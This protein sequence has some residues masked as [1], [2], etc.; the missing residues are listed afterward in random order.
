VDEDRGGG[1]GDGITAV[2]RD[3]PAFFKGVFVE[4]RP[5]DTAAAVLLFQQSDAID[6][7]CFPQQ[8]MFAAVLPV[9]A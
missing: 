4:D 5:A 8:T 1:C 2:E 9:L 3:D 7:R 6:P